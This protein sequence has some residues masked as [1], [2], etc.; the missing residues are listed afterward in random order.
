[1]A[2]KYDIPALMNLS[3]KKFKDRILS[4]PQYDYAGIVSTVLESTHSTDNG[5]RPVI[6]NICDEHM[7]HFLGLD[8]S[9]GEIKVY[10]SHHSFLTVVSNLTT[11]NR[12]NGRMFSPKTVI[13]FTPFFGRLPLVGEILAKRW[14]Q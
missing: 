9:G 1:M 10:H 2:D 8:N 14:L 6:S 13:S 7:D 4:W 3:L 12:T 11:I 5:L